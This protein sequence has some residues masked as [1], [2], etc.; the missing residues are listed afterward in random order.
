MVRWLLA[1]VYLL[2]S[3]REAPR[4]QQINP[5]E[6]RSDEQCERKKRD[7]CKALRKLFSFLGAETWLRHFLLLHSVVDLVQK[8]FMHLVDGPIAVYLNQL[9]LFLIE[10]E[11]VDGVIEKNV[12]PPLN[13]CTPVVRTLVQFAPIDI[14]DTGY[15]RR[16][17]KNVIVVLMCVAEKPSGQPGE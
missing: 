7:S 8:R 4:P 6:E 10:I 5:G 14:A 11:Q 1:R 3:R 17:R 16:V 2:G 12:Q 9:L 15:L 13:R